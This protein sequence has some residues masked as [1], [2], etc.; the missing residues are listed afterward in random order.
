MDA[1]SGSG[2]RRGRPYR[3]PRPTPGRAGWSE[4]QHRIGWLL[5]V[6][7]LYG[8]E[9][10]WQRELDFAADF[11]GGCWAE[12]TSIHRISRW[13]TAAVR[14]PYLA[15]R[16]YE[17][18]LQLPA[19]RLVVLID[20]IYRYSAAVSGAAPLLQRPPHHYVPATVDR[21]D[22]LLEAVRSDDVV[23]GAEWDEL[24]A[25]VAGAGQVIL[26]QSTWALLAERLLAEMIVA[27]GVAWAQRY[28]ALN[29]LLAHPLGQ[30]PA[31]AACASLAA[32]RSNQVFVETVSVLDASPHPDAAAHVI[33]QLINP[34]NDRAQYGALLACVRKVRYGHFTESQIRRLVPIVNE[35]A[36]DPAYY[37]DTRLLATELLRRIPADLPADAR[38]RL[39][40]AANSAA[41]AHR[42]PHGTNPKRSLAERIANTTVA[43]MAREAPRF[44]DTLLPSLVEEM[45]FSPVFDV[46][47][48]AAIL[49]FGTPYRAPLASALALELAGQ[50]AN[51]STEVARALLEALRI[52]GSGEQ[53][54]LVERLTV[55]TGLPAVVT[56]AA[57]SAIGHLGGSSPDHYWTGAID[58]HIRLW[59]TTGSGTSASVLNGLIYGLGITRNSALLCR[60]RARPDAPHPARAA[61]GWWLNLRR[62]VYESANR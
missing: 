1:Q 16:R 52:L 12:R 15:V 50:I 47:L 49:L 56:L 21:M 6:N 53:R 57:A 58:Q 7:R 22:E 39:R 2:S 32:D 9:E 60:V 30:Q 5:R 31:V 54:A 44:P 35:L 11:Q 27:D 36:I 40:H 37:E 10:R 59:R 61:A 14:V 26:P 17:E 29:R 20:S 43:S 19:H 34:T 3:T 41:V 18:L 4:Q 33:R 45:L 24:T 25:L 42:L 13:E 28:E 23:T 62:S 46:R 38:Q 8:P 48:Y 51:G 55:A